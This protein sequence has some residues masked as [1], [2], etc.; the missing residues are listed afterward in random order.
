MA[1]AVSASTAHL[2]SLALAPG[3]NETGY[4]SARSSLE[5]IMGVPLYP[6]TNAPFPQYVCL[7]SFILS[8]LFSTNL[9]TRRKYA[10][11]SS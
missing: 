4:S 11:K 6:D 10:W 1:S 7:L 5:E 9:D 8:L 3:V 2:T